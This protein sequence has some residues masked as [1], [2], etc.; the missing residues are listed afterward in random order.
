MK[1]NEKTVF[2]NTIKKYGIPDQIQLNH[3]RGLDDPDA[4]PIGC[5]LH[6][7]VFIHYLDSV[8]GRHARNACPGP[9]YCIKET[10]QR[11]LIQ[12]RSRAVVYKNIVAWSVDR[13]QPS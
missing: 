3:L 10:F 1:S 9:L 12:K 5:G 11:R 7:A 4:C 13:L 6:I 2:M 8:L